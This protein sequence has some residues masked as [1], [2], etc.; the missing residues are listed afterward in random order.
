ML[1]LLLLVPMHAT[2]FLLSGALVNVPFEARQ[3]TLVFYHVRAIRAS[4]CIPLQC[5][6]ILQY[7]GTAHV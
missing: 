7:T 5:T 6:S 2:A 4:R 3:S 1:L